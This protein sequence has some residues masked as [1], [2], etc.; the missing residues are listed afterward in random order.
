MTLDSTVS[1]HLHALKKKT[2]NLPPTHE[3]PPPILGLHYLQS[4]HVCAFHEP[5]IIQF[6]R[7]IT[8]IEHFRHEIVFGSIFSV[9]HRAKTGTKMEPCLE[10]SFSMMRRGF[11]TILGSQNA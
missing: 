7:R 8:E 2:E 1:H 11:S 4:M 10:S 5:K 9:F 3:N 6:A